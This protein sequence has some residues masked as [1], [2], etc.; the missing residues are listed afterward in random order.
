M[1]WVHDVPEDDLYD[2][3]GY[4]VAVLGNGSEPEPIQVPVPGRE[5]VT[6]P[7]SAWWLYDGSA[8][9]RPRAVAVKAGC[10]CGWR[11]A[12]MFPITWDDHE[13]TEGYEYNEGP[14]Q[15]WD[16]EHIGQLV[17]TAVPTEVTEAIGV[18]RRML[19]GLAETRPLAA[20]AASTE[21][22][23]TGGVN[24]QIAV[25]EARK[26]HASWDAIGNAWGGRTRQAAHQRFSKTSS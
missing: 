22:E 26:R 14:F 7:N 9:D 2:H 15:A 24:L 17:G 10:A 18:L 25:T 4:C 5:G 11:S 19:V 21:V 13:V 16:R 6:T 12:E 8:P 23:R 20:I 1:G 3:E